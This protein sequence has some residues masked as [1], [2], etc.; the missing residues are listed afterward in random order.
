MKVIRNTYGF[1]RPRAH[2]VADAV[3][4][5]LSDA[6]GGVAECAQQVANQTVL[7][8]GK[9]VELLNDRGLL[10]DRE[11]LDTFL[12]GYERAPD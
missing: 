2:T 5:V 11:V 3:T 8:F 10:S 6:D 1:R 12:V 9:L 7:A 4:G